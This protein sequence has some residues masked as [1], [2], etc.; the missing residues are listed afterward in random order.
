MSNWL[1][2]LGVSNVPDDMVSSADE[3]G[4]AALGAAVIAYRSASASNKKV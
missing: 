1:G 2:S 4:D 3:G